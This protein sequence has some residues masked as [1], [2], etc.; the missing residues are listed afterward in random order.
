MDPTTSPSSYPSFLTAF[1]DALLRLKVADVYALTAKAPETRIMTEIEMADVRATVLATVL[2]A[3][4]ATAP[5]TR[6]S[7]ENESTSTDWIA[8]DAVLSDGVPGIVQLKCTTTRSDS[9]Y[10]FT[11]S[12][13][14]AGTHY[15]ADKKDREHADDDL[16]LFLNGEVLRSDSE[17]YAIIRRA[18]D[19][20]DAM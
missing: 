20:V 9:H 19:L 1:H 2:A 17:A 8:T 10:N 4:V 13:T 5:S 14:R 7:T 6:P 11:C 12:T 3:A 15:G 16:Q 18:R